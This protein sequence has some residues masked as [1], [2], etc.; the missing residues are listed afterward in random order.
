MSIQ[1]YPS[2]EQLLKERE[3]LLEENMQ[4]RKE[5]D[6]LKQQLG[7]N[8]SNSEKRAKAEHSAASTVKENANKEN[9]Q[10]VDVT[11]HQPNS[12]MRR[13]SPQEK[14]EVFRALFCGRNDVFARRWFSKSSGK[15]GYQPVCTREWNPQYCDKKKYKCADCPNREFATLAYKD[16]FNHL[17]GKDEY[18]RDVLGIYAITLENKCHFVCADFDDKSCEHGYKDDVLA[19]CAVC[20]D[21]NVPVSIERSR[22]GKGAHVW[23]F[24]SEPLP[25]VKARKLGFAI[26]TEATSRNGRISF[27]SYDRFIPNQD[28]L[29]E[30]GLG[31]LIALPLQGKARREGNSLFVDETFTPYAGQ[32]EYLLSIKKISEAETD[33]ILSQH[34]LMQQD[35]G[36]MSKSS[37]RKPWETPIPTNFS[38]NDFTETLRITKSCMLYV[39]LDGL[40]PKVVNH[41]KR[42]ASFKNPEFYS[43]QAMRFSTFNTPRIICCAEMEDDYIALPRGCEDA[44]MS[45]LQDN[46]VEADIIDKTNNSTQIKADFIG[47]LRTEQK[48]AMLSMVGHTTGVLSATTAFGKTVTAAAIIAEKKVNTLILVHTKALLDQWKERLETFLSLDYTQDAVPNKRGWKK[49][50]SPIGTLCSTGN[51]MHGIIDI[52][53]IQS[54]LSDDDVK[55]FVSGYGMVIVDECH[56]VSSISF[57]TVLKHVNAH[58]VYG[59]TATPIRKDGHQPIIFMQ[60]GPIR[61]IADAKQ[62][63]ES[64]SFSRILIPRYTSFRLLKEDASSYSHVIQKLAEDNLRNELIIEDVSTALGTGRTPLVLTSLTS[65]VETLAAMARNRGC[66]VVTLVGSESVKEK[67]Q[68]ME[69]LKSMEQDE[70]FVIVA[71]GKYV[72]E[73]FDF[74]RLDTL[75]LAMPISWKGIVAQYAG[76]LHRDYKGKTETRIYDY[77]DLR[78][79]IC[80]TMYRRRLH[81]YKSIGYKIQDKKEAADITSANSIFSGT[82]FVE[83]YLSDL[84]TSKSSIVISCPRAKISTAFPNKIVKTLIKMMHEGLEVIVFTREDTGLSSLGID[85]RVHKN[86]S[87]C[88]AIIDKK[89]IW[90]GNANFISGYVRK[91]DEAIRFQDLNVANDLLEFLYGNNIQS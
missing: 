82:D 35:M 2:Y 20:K 11:G 61:Y 73:G 90:Y 72:G 68:K 57:E 22:S 85:V 91:D 63:I 62:Q 51:S 23:I 33:S 64:Q 47:E 59:L 41:L 30:G 88:C 9:S 39:P 29:P 21:W 24:F 48:E 52:A 3:R 31:N 76:R 38:Q 79:Q 74:A 15:G 80:E 65:H 19:Y 40:S 4:L 34:S 66:R 70:R 7:I 67:R 16:V 54:C 71:T 89:Q 49:K 77:V 55:P 60:C 87:L 83:P 13:L 32:W 84:C 5:N 78:V 14:V 28:Y 46:K 25:V 27:K 50:W 1:N 10:T 81:G 56:H 53:T 75:F 26:L 58:F 69:E 12:A 37:E 42:L 18:G 6:A 36:A 45:L 8:V 43:K 86:L 44:L 17:A